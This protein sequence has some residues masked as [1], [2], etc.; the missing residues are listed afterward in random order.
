M[1][2]DIDLAGKGHNAPS[3]FPS[4]KVKQLRKTLDLFE[5]EAKVRNVL[6]LT[7]NPQTKLALRR[8]VGILE[9]WRA[10]SVDITLDNEDELV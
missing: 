7:K 3:Y 6:A 10:L 9:V 4:P 5:D 2:E 8:L 1:Q